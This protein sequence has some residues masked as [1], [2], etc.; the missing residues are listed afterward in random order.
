[1]A[2]PPEKK[3][4]FTTRLPEHT[5][6]LIR[7]LSQ[8]EQVLTATIIAELVEEAI[9]ARVTKALTPP[10]PPSSPA[11]LVPFKPQREMSDACALVL[12]EIR[13]RG[14]NKELENKLEVAIRELREKEKRE[15]GKE[16]A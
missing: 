8:N 6:K 3:V 14:G 4:T 1:V 13:R 10:V 5:A 7:G 16:E 15:M 12:K 9:Q 11:P 2:K